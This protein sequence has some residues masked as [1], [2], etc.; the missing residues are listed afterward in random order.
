M[1]KITIQRGHLFESHFENAEYI[2]P[3]SSEAK[4]KLPELT[5]R[6]LG[7]FTQ[8]MIEKITSSRI[9]IAG[10]GG[11]G[12][13]VADSL[14]RAGV[15][16][17]SLADPGIFDYSNIHRQHA[18]SIQSVGTSKVFAT[19]NMLRSTVT[20][21]DISVFP[22]GI[23]PESIDSFLNT[24]DIVIDAIEY[25]A[26]G[27]RY[28]LHSAARVKGIP[29]FNGNSVGFSTNLF[30]FSPTEQSLIEVL[31]FNEIYAYYL[32]NQFL[33][34][35]IS[36]EE[37]SYICKVINTIFL[38]NLPNYGGTHNTKESFLQRIHNERTASIITTNPKMASGILANHILLHLVREL[39]EYSQKLQ[40]PTFPE[41]Y[42]YD[43]ALRISETRS[44]NLQKMLYE[45]NSCM[46]G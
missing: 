36:Q 22:M 4:K 9:A 21:T 39:E 26:L 7:W 37:Y 25:H 24:A 18:A 30:H 43:T 34:E 11:I 19:A 12:G 3:A 31:P 10:V 45:L 46:P 13:H 23:S 17:I 44:H 41:Y 42:H 15:S 5:D 29:V 2:F 16:H 32:E 38:P 33:S 1:K 35:N 40:I 6:T 20:S 28:S 27:A 8:A 14:V